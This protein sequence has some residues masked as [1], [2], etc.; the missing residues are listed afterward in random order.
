MVEATDVVK[1]WDSERE[2]S[3]NDKARE[4]E[5]GKVYATN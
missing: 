1:K 2:L 4:Q 5:E 3:A